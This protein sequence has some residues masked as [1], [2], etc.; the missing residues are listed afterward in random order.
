MSAWARRSRSPWSPLRARPSTRR[1]CWPT[2]GSTSPPSWCRRS[3]RCATSASPAT[4]A[5][6]SSSAS[7][8]T[9]PRPPAARSSRSGRASGCLNGPERGQNGSGGGGLGAADQL[10][11]QGA[12]GLAVA[13][14]DLA[15]DD[16][17]PVAGG[18]LD[19]ALPAGGEVLD[20]LRGE[21]AEL[22]LVDQVQ[23]GPVAG[24][25]DAAVV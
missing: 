6:R 8:A 23:V 16:G 25:Q 11:G 24:D 2:C 20:H 19:V 15:G 1:P 7:S 22:L 21:D 10:A 14:G 13:E 4:P 12:G 9:P 18:P 5:A 17:R 3:S